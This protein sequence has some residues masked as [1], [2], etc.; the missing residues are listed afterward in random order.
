MKNKEKY[1]IRDLARPK[2][3]WDETFDEGFDT[4]TRR[5]LKPN[6]KEFGLYIQ[7]AEE[8]YPEIGFSTSDLIDLAIK[9]DCPV[10]EKE[11]K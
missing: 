3:R 5:I 11:L 4:K 6:Y 1:K 2:V 8:K 10:T 7:E 9:Y